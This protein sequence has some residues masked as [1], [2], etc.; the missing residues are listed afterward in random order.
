MPHEILSREESTKKTVYLT[1]EPIS[2]VY[3]AVKE[4]MGFSE[5]TVTP[6][7]YMLEIV[8]AYAILYRTV[9][10]NITI[11]EWNRLPLA[12]KNWKYSNFLFR[13]VHRKI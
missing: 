12:N 11:Q 7:T 4:L 8:I 2:S 1:L 5:I 3:T 10:F 13:T 9:T 6:Y